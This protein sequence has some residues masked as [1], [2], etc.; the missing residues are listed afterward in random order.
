MWRNH[1]VSDTYEPGSTFKL[2]TVA[3]GVETG[4]VSPESTFVCGGSMMV[5]GWDKPIRCHKTGGHGAQTLEQALMN[6]CNV[7]MMQISMKMGASNFYDYFEAFGMTQ[8]PASTCP[9]R[10][11]IKRSFTIKRH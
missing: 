5:K 11:T 2:M 1:I 9:V 6:S 7:A 3:S 10:Q 8:R 4:T